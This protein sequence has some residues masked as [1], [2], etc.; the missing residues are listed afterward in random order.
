MGA[1][2]LLMG[3]IGFFVL[4]SYLK[5]PPPY[6]KKKFVGAFDTMVMTVCTVMC[7]SWVFYL[8]GG[9]VNTPEEKLWQPL[10]ILGALGIEIVFLGLCFLLRNFWVFKPPRRPGQDGFF[11]F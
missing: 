10:A 6:A 8:R 4:F 1:V 11:G 2:V 3:I 9:L 5:F 7:L